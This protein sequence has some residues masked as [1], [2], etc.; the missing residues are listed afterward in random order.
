MARFLLERGA[1]LSLENQDGVTA[2]EAFRKQGRD[3]IA[4]LLRRRS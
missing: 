2:E 1:D 3:E 4:D